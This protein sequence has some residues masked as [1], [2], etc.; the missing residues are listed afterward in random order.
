MKEHEISLTIK[1][2]IINSVEYRELNK[3]QF[4]STKS[5]YFDIFIGS[6]RYKSKPFTLHETSRYIDNY[7]LFKIVNL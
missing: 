4:C 2:L 7:S 1:T 5:Y 3:E 6:Y